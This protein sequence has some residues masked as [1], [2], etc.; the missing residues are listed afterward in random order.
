MMIKAAKEEEKESDS[1]MLRKK[2]EIQFKIRRSVKKD[3]QNEDKGYKMTN[4]KLMERKRNKDHHAEL[5]AAPSFLSKLFKQLT[6]QP[7]LSL[8]PCLTVAVLQLIHATRLHNLNSITKPYLTLP[9]ST[10]Q[11]TSLAFF[12]G[13]FA[14]C[15][16]YSSTYE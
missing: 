4:L 15:Q 6:Q 3:E 5:F 10:T 2:E 13:S 16:V 11:L 12:P 9:H 8:P 7:I 14:G 1:E